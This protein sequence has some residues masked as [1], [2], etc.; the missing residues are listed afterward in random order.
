MY[1]TEPVVKITHGKIF[2]LERV[3]KKAVKQYTIEPE[4]AL[5]ATR[6][7]TEMS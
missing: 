5:S 7:K 6:S 1:T 4:N 2:R 3:V